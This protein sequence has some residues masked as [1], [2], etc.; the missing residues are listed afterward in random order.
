MVREIGATTTVQLTRGPIPVRAPFWSPDGTRVYFFR[1]ATL[2][3]VSAVGGEPELVIAGA[4]SAALHPRDGRFVFARAGQLWLFD[5]SSTTGAQDPQPFG[6]APFTGTSAIPSAGVDPVLV[7]AFSDDGSKL[8]VVRTGRLWLLSYP[9]G[10]ARTIELGAFDGLFVSWLPDSRHVVT[11]RV[12]DGQGVG[13][14][15]VDT[16]TGTIRTILTGPMLL[17]DPRASPDGKRMA[18]VTGDD[19]SKL[20]EVTVADGRTRE[21]GSGVRVSMFPSLSPDGTRLAFVDHS[22]TKAGAIREMMLEP[23]GETVARTIAVVEGGI[24]EHVQ[25][26]PDGARI[27]FTALTADGRSGLMVAPAGGGRALPVDAAAVIS[28]GGS[29]SPD[30]TRIAYRRQV[31]DE[32]QIVTVR[33]GTSAAPSVVK[34]WPVGETLYLPQG[35]SPDGRWI[36]VRREADVSL[37]ASDGSSERPLFSTTGYTEFA[38]LIFSRDG[39]EVLMLRRDMSRAGHGAWKLFATDIASGA[40]RVM[41]TVD[42]PRTAQN[43]AGLSFSPDGKRLY[44][45]YADASFD[46]WML[47]GFQ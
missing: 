38:R 8:A 21:L 28:R 10:T 15:L 11:A 31:G 40:E 19:R 4:T 16:E 43:L 23:T 46:I 33:V 7:R 6:Q 17:M 9:G 41:T 45:S 37:L 1:A 25:W 39:R 12:Q 36:L 2:W 18:F 30:G 26:S 35:W 13:L 3:S 44:T 20:I 47:E 42:L 22:A 29:W 14:A 5:P 34:R 27:L 24:P 32:H